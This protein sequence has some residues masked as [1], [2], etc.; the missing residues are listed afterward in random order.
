MV[1]DRKAGNLISIKVKEA[2]Y[3]RR[4]LGR[5]KRERGDLCQGRGKLLFLCDG[6]DATSWTKSHEEPLP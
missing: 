1:R 4:A 2:R 6:K 3:D 5:T